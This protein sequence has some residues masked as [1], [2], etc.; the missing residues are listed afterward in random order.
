MITIPDHGCLK[1]MVD[2]YHHTR[3]SVI[4]VEECDPSE[5]HK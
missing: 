2:L 4:A 5:A 3:G 1:D